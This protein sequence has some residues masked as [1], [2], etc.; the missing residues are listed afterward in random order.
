MKVTEPKE[1]RTRL[2]IPGFGF[3]M[4]AKNTESVSFGKNAILLGC[5][6]EIRIMEGLE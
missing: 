5:E 4:C 6:V 3:S 1:G 2:K